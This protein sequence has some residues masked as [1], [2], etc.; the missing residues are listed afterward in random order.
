LEG[1]ND[2][3][4]TGIG[5]PED[6]RDKIFE[7]FYQL[8]NP[9]RD[10]KKGLGLGLAIARRLEQ[11]LGY[12]IELESAPE[13]SSAFSLEVPMARTYS[14]TGT[15]SPIDRSA[16][17]IN[18]RLLLVIDDELAARDGTQVVMSGWGCAVVGRVDGGSGRTVAQI[19]AATGSAHCRL[20]AAR[21]ASPARTRLSSWRTIWKR[22]SRHPH[23]LRIT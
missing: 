18:E 21:T 13:R 22:Y 11:L 4:D 5:I 15:V 2:V 6:K 10:R 16:A 9:E 20:P 23:H 17:N 19:R 8:G 12:K 1:Q 3:R 14:N 7:E